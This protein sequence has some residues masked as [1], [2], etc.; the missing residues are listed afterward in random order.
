MKKITLLVVLCLCAAGCSIP[1]SLAEGGPI[2]NHRVDPSSKVLILS[3]ADG[4]EQGQERAPGSG[5]GM[6]SAIRKVLVAH[7]VPL[8][9]TGTSALATGLDEARRG[10]F[11]Y[12]LKGTI[13]LWE[14]NATAWSGNGDKLTLSLDLYDAKSRELIAASTHRRVATGATFVSG[15]PD[16]FMDEVSAGALDKIYAWS[17]L[18]GGQLAST[19]VAGRSNKTVP[20]QSATDAEAMNV[21]LR[22]L[23]KESLDSGN[24]KAAK[25]YLD[26]IVPESGQH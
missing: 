17:E 26:M 15:S 8:S 11:D 24:Q 20:S 18:K 5:Q 14:D 4:Q 25:E 2:A 23:A 6:V 21:E 9:T 13:T 19:A 1:R 3:I 10:G 12:A 16:R 22:R 7:G